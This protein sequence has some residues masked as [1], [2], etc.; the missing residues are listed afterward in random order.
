VAGR[1]RQSRAGG[2]GVNWWQVV[3]VVVQVQVGAAGAVQVAGVQWWWWCRQAEN[4][5]VQKWQVVAGA[6]EPSGSAVAV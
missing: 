6:G 4:P 5:N 2:S 3:V 1:C